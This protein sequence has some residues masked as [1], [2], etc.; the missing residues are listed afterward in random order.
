LR[1]TVPVIAVITAAFFSVAVITAQPANAGVKPSGGP[2]AL[3]V[4]VPP[5]PITIA[6]GASGKA[7][8]RVV[9]PNLAPVAVTV[10]SRQLS[11]GDNGKV[12][13]GAG[14]DPLWQ[15][16]APFPRRQLTIPAQGYLDIPLAIQVPRRLAPDL[17]FIGFLVTPVATQAGGLRVINQIGSFV[18]IDVPGPR[19]R[20]LAAVFD[21]PSFVLGSHVSGTMRIANVGR[22]AV[23]F[24]G[25][26]DTTSSPGGTYHQLRLNPSLLPAGRSRSITVTGKPAWPIGMVTITTHLTYPGRSEAQTKELTFNKRV[27]VV[28]PWVPIALLSILLIAG[29]LIWRRRRRS[30]SPKTAFGDPLAG[31][32]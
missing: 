31:S 5:D 25:E 2:R 30:R 1:T 20:K 19:V 32:R 8:V 23:R 10:A 22:A 15:K 12:S 27:L 28:A 18:T 26:D 6:A 7:L 4:S 11:L 14:V 9:N 24:W 17:Y 21:I 13:V 3:A 29:T 16:R